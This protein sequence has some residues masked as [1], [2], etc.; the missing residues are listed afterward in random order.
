MPVPNPETKH[1]PVQT[2]RVTASALRLMIQ[3][4]NADRNTPDSVHSCVLC[5]TICHYDEMSPSFWVDRGNRE[6][7]EEIHE[8]ICMDCIHNCCDPNDPDGDY[9]LT[10]EAT[11]SF[12]RRLA[13]LG[14]QALA[15]GEPLPV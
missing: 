4:T 10:P 13:A 3:S 7:C 11:A 9:T 15:K 12:D 6:N 5:G 1:L 14:R 2:V 8:P